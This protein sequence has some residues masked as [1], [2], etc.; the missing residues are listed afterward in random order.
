MTLARLLL[1]CYDSYVLGS[2]TL[3][4]FESNFSA[5]LLFL[6]YDSHVL[7]LITIPVL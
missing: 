3:L 7:D 6:Y 2:I 1:L 5:R 4:V